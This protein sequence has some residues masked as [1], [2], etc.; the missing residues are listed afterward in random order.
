VINIPGCIIS[1]LSTIAIGQ[2]LDFPKY[3]ERCFPNKQNDIQLQ[4]SLVRVN[5]YR[6][7]YK[8]ECTSHAEFVDEQRM[9]AEKGDVRV[10]ETIGHIERR[11]EEHQIKLNKQISNHNNL[12][13]ESLGVLLQEY[14]MPF[15]YVFR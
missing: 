13:T 4:L 6:N 3:Q 7:G 14:R 11:I 8:Y 9:A 1:K 5:P 15:N 12:Y 10:E 2:W